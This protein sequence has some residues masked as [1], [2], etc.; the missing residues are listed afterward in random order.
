MTMSGAPVRPVEIR[1]AT[2]ISA[3]EVLG[4]RDRREQAQDGG[5]FFMPPLLQTTPSLEHRPRPREEEEGRGRAAP[6]CRSGLISLI[7]RNLPE[8]DVHAVASR[9]PARCP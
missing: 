7:W 8:L 3:V 1:E 9:A 5:S 4:E 2:S 6:G